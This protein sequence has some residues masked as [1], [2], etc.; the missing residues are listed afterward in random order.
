MPCRF[1]ARGTV[2]SQSNNTHTVHMETARRVRRIIVRAL[3]WIRRQRPNRRRTRAPNLGAMAFRVR[4][5]IG[6]VARTPTGWT[7]D[8]DPFLIELIERG[9]PVALP[10]VHP[11]PIIQPDPDNEIWMWLHTLNQ[12]NLAGYS[13]TTTTQPETLPD[14]R[15][16][17]DVTA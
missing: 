10:L 16:P 3:T 13:A 11:T 15:S 14:I 8:S 2:D 4:T 7:D 6:D 17:R 9:R 5:P 1:P 12:L